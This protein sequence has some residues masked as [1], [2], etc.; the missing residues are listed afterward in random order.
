MKGERRE[1]QGRKG[2]E[3]KETRKGED[4]STVEEEVK[5]ERGSRRRGDKE[6]TEKEG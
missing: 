1:E 3:G 5:K 6:T 4:V 2:S